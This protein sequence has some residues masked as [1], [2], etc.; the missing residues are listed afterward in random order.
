M[1]LATA[2]VRV[3]WLQKTPFVVG[4]GEQH[5]SEIREGKSDSDRLEK[6]CRGPVHAYSVEIGRS[7]L[8]L[9][10]I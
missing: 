10:L 9:D 7:G 1:L 6:S 4:S 2:R 8:L 5:F 3:S